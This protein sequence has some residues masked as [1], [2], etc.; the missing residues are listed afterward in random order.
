MSLSLMFFHLSY[1]QLS[2]TRFCQK[3]Y[4]ETQIVENIK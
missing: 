4:V 3:M 1:I 2:S